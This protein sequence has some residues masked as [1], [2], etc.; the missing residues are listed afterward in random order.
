MKPAH[1]DT[2]V[3]DRDDEVGLFHDALAD[4]SRP[5]NFVDDVVDLGVRNV[6]GRAQGSG[7]QVGWVEW[8]VRVYQRDRRV[9]DIRGY[10]PLP[11]LRAVRTRRQP[12]E[13]VKHTDLVL[14]HRQAW[15]RDSL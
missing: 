2:P 12:H 14:R 6:G 13:V 9:D 7:G 5:A 15:L 8:N 11:V 10:R 4:A 1:P 3:I